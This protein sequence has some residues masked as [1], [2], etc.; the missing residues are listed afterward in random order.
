[1]TPERCEVC[2]YRGIGD[3]NT[4]LND[5]LSMA[6]TSATTGCLHQASELLIQ[7]L[8]SAYERG[9]AKGE[10][11]MASIALTTVYSPG[12]DPL[13]EAAFMLT[14][15]ETPLL[16]RR[17]AAADNPAQA[18]FNLLVAMQDEMLLAIRGSEVSH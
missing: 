6:R 17:G 5:R 12:A 2:D 3:P 13:Y 8:H 16:I 9:L 10:Q 14:D 15:D 1:M 7:L 11:S 4:T 18:S